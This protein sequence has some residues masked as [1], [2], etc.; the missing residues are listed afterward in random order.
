ML[1]VIRSGKF[2]DGSVWQP[3]RTALVE[4]EISEKPQVGSQT[5]AIITRYEPNRIAVTTKADTPSI[6]VLSENHYAGWRAYVDSRFVETLRVDYNLRG[7]ALP[8]GEHRVEFVYRPK[9]FSMGLT[10][11]LLAV[12]GL[13]SWPLIQKK[14]IRSLH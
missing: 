12:V 7:V 2:Q 4:G 8:A 11:S 5:S 14:F 3:E 10:M 1:E 6:L 9:S 13:V